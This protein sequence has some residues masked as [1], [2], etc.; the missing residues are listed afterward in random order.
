MP[1]K[2]VKVKLTTNSPKIIQLWRRI[3]GS[4]PT[5]RRRLARRE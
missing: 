3:C 2:S 1:L 4:G 5:L